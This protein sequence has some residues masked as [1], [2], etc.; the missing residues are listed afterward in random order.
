MKALLG[1]GSLGDHREGYHK[2]ENKDALDQGRRHMLKDA[3]KKERGYVPH[4]SRYGRKLVLLCKNNGKKSF[5]S[6]HKEFDVIP[7][8]IDHKDSYL[9][10]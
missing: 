5:E 1:S 10:E 2:Q 9:P 6:S 4:V 7:D 8:A 3:S